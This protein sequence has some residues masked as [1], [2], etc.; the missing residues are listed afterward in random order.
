MKISESPRGKS[1]GKNPL[2]TPF[3]IQKEEEEVR[4]RKGGETF[5]TVAVGSFLVLRVELDEEKE[6]RKNEKMD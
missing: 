3:G 1:K 2:Q 4:R 5:S 6:G